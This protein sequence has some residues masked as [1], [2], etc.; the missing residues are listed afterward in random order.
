MACLENIFMQSVQL[1]YEFSYQIFKMGLV[2]TRQS[3]VET[4]A[5]SSDD[6]L[7]ITPNT[8][9][10]ISLPDF[11]IADL[12]PYLDVPPCCPLDTDEHSSE[13]KKKRNITVVSDVELAKRN[14]ARIPE[15]TKWSTDWCVR[16]WS[17]WAE[18]RR[19]SNATVTSDLYAVVNSNVLTSSNVELNYWL[20]KF[21]VEVREKIHW[22]SR[23]RLT[24]CTSCAVAFSDI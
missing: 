12:L 17:E 14:E 16:T 20:S 11:D 24:L 1:K 5:T 10:N 23:I 22:G 4:M 13:G 9:T 15:G 2:L 21:V 3:E 19:S 8:F 6:D 18:E 7:F